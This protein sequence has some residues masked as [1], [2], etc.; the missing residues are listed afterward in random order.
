MRLPRWRTDGLFL[1][2]NA[3]KLPSRSRSRAIEKY[4]AVLVR[5]AERWARP[6]LPE[7][8]Y[9]LGKVDPFEFFIRM[10][11]GAYRRAIWQPAPRRR[12]KLATRPPIPPLEIGCTLRAVERMHDGPSRAFVG[13][14]LLEAHR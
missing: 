9:Y 10:Y 8:A 3:R 2:K 14:Y 1:A 5:A 11:R 6:R 4:G 13:A 12:S 7:V